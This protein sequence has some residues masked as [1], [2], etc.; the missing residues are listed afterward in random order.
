MKKRDQ[1]NFAVDDE[2]RTAL[3]EIRSMC[4][5]VPTISQAI[6]QAI[7]NERDRLRKRVDADRRKEGT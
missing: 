2:V 1:L 4:R 6:R 3:D 5:P 7:F